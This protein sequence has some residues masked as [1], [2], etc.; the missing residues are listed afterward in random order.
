MEPPEVVNVPAEVVVVPA[1]LVASVE[2]ERVL[3]LVEVALESRADCEE[4][5]ED[6]LDRI[7]GS[8]HRETYCAAALHQDVCCCPAGIL[9]GSLGQLL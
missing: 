4:A 2:S 9:A 1:A 6:S 5:L 8:A 3:V 7:D